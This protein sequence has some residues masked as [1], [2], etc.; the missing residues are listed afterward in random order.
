MAI[1]PLKD[2]T[3]TKEFDIDTF[4]A[5]DDWKYLD[6]SFKLRDWQG[7]YKQ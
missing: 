1:E 7:T 5:T 4:L 2:T 3:G 6:V